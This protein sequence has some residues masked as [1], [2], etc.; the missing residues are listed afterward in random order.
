MP[1]PTSRTAG[2]SASRRGNG[3]QTTTLHPL[4]RRELG[5]VD[6]RRMQVVATED[7]VALDVILWNRPLGR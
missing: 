2:Y 6:L 1:E 7:G 3:V 5:L 4:I